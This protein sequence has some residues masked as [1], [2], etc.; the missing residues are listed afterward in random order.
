MRPRVLLSLYELRRVVAWWF[1]ITSGRLYIYPPGAWE[2]VGC[3]TCSPSP[4]PL[5]LTRTLY[6]FDSSPIKLV[7][8]LVLS[9]TS[10]NAC[11]V[12]GLVRLS[13]ASCLVGTNSSLIL[14]L[15]SL[16]ADEVVAD[17]DVLWFCNGACGFRR[18][19]STLAS[20]G[21]QV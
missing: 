12:N 4:S 7:L 14:C 5:P 13:A 16:S 2:V 11:Q 18:G 9:R 15:V 20:R 6:I 8:A 3:V 19:G 17:F 1:G 10:R 21:Q